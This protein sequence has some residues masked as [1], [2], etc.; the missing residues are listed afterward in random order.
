M[1]EKY[2]NKIK[3]V[4]ELKKI[5]GKF[6]RNKKVIMCH[7]VFDVVH[8]GHI[9][10]LA[11]A[12]SKADILVVS[13]TSD[14]HITKGKYR[15]HV[16]EKIRAINIATFEMVDYVL[17]DFNKTPNK[18]L[19]SIKPDYFAKGFE[20]TSNGLPPATIAENKILTSY[21]GSIIFTPGDIVYSSSKI[22]D[23]NLPNLQVE[24]LISI[25]N[26]YKIDFVKLKQSLRNL[27]KLK[28]HVIGDTIIDSYT[29]TTMIGGQVKTPTISV[30]HHKREDYLGGA[31]IV[32]RHIRAAGAKVIFTT[33][34]GNDNFKKLVK[35]K[36]KNDGILLNAI[37]D[38][39]RPTTHKNT[40]V[41]DQYRLLKIDTLDNRPISEEALNV[42][43]K[44]IK[45]HKV[46]AVIFSDFRHGIF[47]SYTIKKLTKAIPKNLFKVADSQVAT[48]WGNICD[49]KNFDLITPNEREARF[50]LADQDSN[51]GR[52]TENLRKNSNFKNLILKLGAKGVFC[53]GNK[54]KTNEY[55]SIDSFVTKLVDAVGAGDALLAYGTLVYLNTK[56]LLLA[57][58]IGSIAAS[59]ECE[60]DGNI[61]IKPKNIEHKIDQ[62][63]KLMGYSSSNNI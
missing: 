24:K 31:G 49:F 12:K 58:I 34:V 33:V 26:E 28:V 19:L 39:S 7:G 36:C 23:T 60:I 11:Y 27:N 52:L 20:Y 25:M 63:E 13:L 32:S 57:G 47:N 10:H 2:Q 37:E 30:L 50:S 55:F 46:N 48:R 40:I 53:V 38:R 9:R 42:I 4:K 51:I 8:P 29:R 61:P 62:I 15:P 16:P 5:I 18:N 21:G 45:K 6:P 35:Q 43:E 1:L 3:T 59:C 14:I 44:K 54:N 41:T 17:I 56:S 22:L